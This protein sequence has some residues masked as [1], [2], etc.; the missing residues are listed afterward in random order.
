MYELRCSTQIVCVKQLARSWAQC[1][2]ARALLQQA[3]S[4]MT[5]QKVTGTSD[6]PLPC[7]LL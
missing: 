2:T 4:C 3:H 5:D 1:V 6:G 7:V